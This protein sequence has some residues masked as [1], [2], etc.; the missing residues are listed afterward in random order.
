[1][2]RNITHGIRQ[3]YSKGCRCTDCKA[4]WAAYN[5]ERREARA[6]G[7]SQT[8]Q[9]GTYGMYTN[10]GCRCQD[11]KHAAF[12]YQLQRNYGITHDEYMAMGEA[13]DWRCASCRNDEPGSAKGWHLDHNHASGVVRGLLCHGC[14][15]AFGML[16]ESVDRISGLLGYA[17]RFTPA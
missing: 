6:R 10:N 11:C 2:D 13:Q 16:G 4:A 12:G 9:H 15:V 17:R 3:G 8:A 7:E 14:N 1:M 5:K